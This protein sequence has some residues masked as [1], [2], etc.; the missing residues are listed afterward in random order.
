VTTPR[1]VGVDL[2]LTSTGLA[3]SHG[4]T[5]RYRTKPTKSPGLLDDLGR[6]E[7]ITHAVSMFSVF[8]PDGWSAAL[9]VIEGPAFSRGGMGGQHVRAGLWWAI[10]ARLSSHDVL[11][12]LIVPP[13]VRAM[14]ATGRGNA[15]KDEVL[16]AAIKRYPNWDITGN[17]VADAVILAAIGAR[18]LGHPVDDLPKTHLRALAKVTLPTT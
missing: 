13:N 6:I 1:V 10:A 11:R 7:R 2:S 9:V 16:A 8:G 4:A 17:D 12:L 15:G 5:D 14:Y 18:L 3:D